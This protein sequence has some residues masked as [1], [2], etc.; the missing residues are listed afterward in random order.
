MP[1]FAVEPL[2]RLTRVVLRAAGSNDREAE[3]VA[4]HLVT[5]NLTGHDSHGVGML[6]AYL[7][8]IRAGKL[9]PNRKGQV[10]AAG[11]ATLVIDGERG[12]GQVIAAGAIDRALPIVRDLGVAVVPVRA[13]HHVGRVGTYAEMALTAGFASVHFV[14][15]NAGDPPVVP[16]GGKAGRFATNPIAIGVPG[17]AAN[18]PFLLDFATSRLAMGKVRVAHNRGVAMPPGVLLDP[19]GAPTTDPGVMFRTPRGAL[20]PFGEYKGYGLALAAE[21][22]AGAVGGAGTHHQGVPRDR[23]IVNGMLSILIDPAHF[24]DQGWYADAYDQMIDHV[25]A[26]PPVDPSRP[27]LIAGDPERAAKVRRRQDG[28][29]VEERT[30]TDIVAA[31]AAFGVAESVF[32]EVAT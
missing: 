9:L 6:P 17:T 21:L 7:A 3:V 4:D 19:D 26:T 10:V 20:L 29:T 25:R 31:A 16:W 30:W 8:N 5:A 27:V 1:T 24:A 32:T 13:T 15:G 11:G 14:N 23:G 12:Y 2:T 28:I 18:P 22:L